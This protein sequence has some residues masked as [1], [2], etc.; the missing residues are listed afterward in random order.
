MREQNGL[1]RSEYETQ[2][3]VTGKDGVVRAFKRFC[4]TMSQALKILRQASHPLQQRDPIP[5]ILDKD[6][7]NIIKLAARP[8]RATCISNLPLISCVKYL[9]LGS[10]D[11]SIAV[12]PRSFIASKTPGTTR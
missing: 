11:Q 9:T 6:K 8:N 12:A 3:A 5:T 2:V 1:N 4:S 10:V 7:E